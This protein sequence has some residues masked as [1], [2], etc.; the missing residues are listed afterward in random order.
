[1]VHLWKKSYPS[2]CMKHGKK[3]NGVQW[4]FTVLI[5]ENRVNL[6]NFGQSDSSCYLIVLVLFKG[7]RLQI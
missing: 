5:F 6:V 1:M 2:Q 4:K 3:N 7:I